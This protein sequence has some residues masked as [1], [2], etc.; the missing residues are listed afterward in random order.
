MLPIWLIVGPVRSAETYARERCW[1]SD[2]VEFAATADGLR[3]VFDPT[4]HERVVLVDVVHLSPR[5]R[6]AIAEEIR[7]IHLVWPEI[8]I[9]DPSVVAQIDDDPG[10][11]PVLC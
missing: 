8:E 11:V 5:E 6:V 1:R 4:R 10:R 7:T 3:C 9:S 2:L